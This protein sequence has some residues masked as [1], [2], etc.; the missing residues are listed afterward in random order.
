MEDY[1]QHL[2]SYLPPT[3]IRTLSLG[4]VIPPSNLLALPL[5]TGPTGLPFDFTFSSRNQPRMIDE[6]GRAILALT[7]QIPDGL[8]VFFPSYGYLAQVVSRWKI[9]TSISQTTTSTAT[10]PHQTTTSTL[11]PQHQNIYASLTAVKPIFSESKSTPVDELLTAYSQAISAG[12]GRGALLLAVIGGSLSEGINF[13]DELGRGVVVVGLPFPNNQ[14][15]EWR[16]KLAHVERSAAAARREAE[17]DNG[18]AEANSSKIAESQGTA[19]KTFYLNTTMRAVNQSIGRAIRH[20]GDYAAIVL[21]DRR[22]GTGRIV[23]KLPGWIREGVRE[24]KGF[25]GAMGSV[26]EFFAGKGAGG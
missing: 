16:A 23:E 18:K 19:A 6:L 15:A 14:S 10:S 17:A 21:V 1:T 5:P 22:Y 2:L 8:V 12:Q 13:S 9:A 3:R 25:E 4:H 24:C 26:G 7:S 11:R 20:R